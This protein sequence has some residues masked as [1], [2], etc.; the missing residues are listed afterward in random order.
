M[1]VSA[2][3]LFYVGAVLVVNGLMLL[4]RI[5]PKGAAPLNLFVGALQVVTPS[6]LI[7]TADGDPAVILG[8]AGLY[9]FGFTYLWVGINN[10]ASLPGEGLGWFSLFVAIAAIAYA[11][12]NLLDGAYLFALIWLLWSVLWL[13]FFAV[14]A[15]GRTGLTAFTGWVALL[16]GVFTAAVP[17]WLLLIGEWEETP[18][19]AGIAGGVSLIVLIGAWFGAKATLRRPA[20]PPDASTPAASATE[21][22]ET[23]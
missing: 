14:L 2:V 21:S 17:A 5:P 10:L 4:G 9:L 7:L 15:L 16:E 1:T 22:S 23:A 6:Y 3:G 8:A 12:V 11:V 19:A 13:L 18:L 20:A